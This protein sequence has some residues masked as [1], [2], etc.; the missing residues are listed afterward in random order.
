MGDET[1][2]TKI[3][4]YE[5][6]YELRDRGPDYNGFFLIWEP[7]GTVKRRGGAIR[8]HTDAGI[9]GEYVGGTFDAGIYAGYLVGK[10]PLA[11]E[12][13][14]NDVKRALRHTNNADYGAAE[15]SSSVLMASTQRSRTTILS[16]FQPVAIPFS[17]SGHR[18][19]ERG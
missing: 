3:E 5:F 16:S 1:R 2:I 7:G 18:R 14:F 13:L 4:V 12:L 17:K 6:E 11:R 9:T 10:D 15:I 8:I 19:S